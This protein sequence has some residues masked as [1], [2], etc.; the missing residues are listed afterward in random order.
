MSSPLWRSLAWWAGG[1]TEY[2]RGIHAPA[3]RPAAAALAPA[4]KRAKK[5]LPPDW[6]FLSE[7]APLFA[8]G[9]LLIT[10]LQLTGL[11]DVFQNI[12][13]PVTT[14]L[15]RLPR[16]TA[17]A[18]IMGIMRRD[19]GAPG[20][21]DINLTPVQTLVALVTITLFV[22]CI[23]SV[24]IIFKERT[25][26]ESAAIWAGSFVTAF[27]TGGILA[28]LM[29]VAG[30]TFVCATCGCQ[31]KEPGLRCPR[32]QEPLALCVH[33]LSAEKEGKCPGGGC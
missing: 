16:E 15:L 33:R 1:S 28:W 29:G 20:L 32:C 19:F 23:A 11:L 25:W 7:A 27:L 3:H 13:A 18:F 2:C 12:M 26:K 22:P 17:T 24:T 5:D 14:G 8:L 4:G 21:Y 30:M 9:A 6:H 31:L 10:V